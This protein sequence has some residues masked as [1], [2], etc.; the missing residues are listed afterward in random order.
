M[1]R[2]CSVLP[3]SL[4]DKNPGGGRKSSRL[5]A[6]FFRARISFFYPSFFSFSRSS[7]LGRVFL[8]LGFKRPEKT[9]SVRDKEKRR[10]FLE[11]HK[12]WAGSAGRRQRSNNN[13]APTSIWGTE[14]EG[15]WLFTIFPLTPSR[16]TFLFVRA[17][18]LVSAAG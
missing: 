18:V 10:G 9:Q 1:R 14:N 15:N 5:R 3:D 11:L 4:G 17:A 8:C 7:F 12:R 13:V 6:S 2:S 16:C